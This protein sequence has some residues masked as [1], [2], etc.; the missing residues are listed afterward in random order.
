MNSDY[1]ERLVLFGQEKEPVLK[2]DNCFNCNFQDDCF[3]KTNEMPNIDE[4]NYE[5]IQKELLTFHD[6]D[7]EVPF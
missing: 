6:I 4:K 2:R 5:K 3:E 7:L 1:C